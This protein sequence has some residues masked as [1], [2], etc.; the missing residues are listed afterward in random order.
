MRMS[1][2]ALEELDKYEKRFAVEHELINDMKCY[3]LVNKTLDG[4]EYY[5]SETY[6]Y[7]NNYEIDTGEY[8]FMVE[9]KD[10]MVMDYEC[11]KS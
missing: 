7:G 1:L 11:F 9:V 6:G 3:L 2:E 5:G 4:Y 10:D 8:T